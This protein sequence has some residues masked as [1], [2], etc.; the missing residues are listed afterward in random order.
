M[1]HRLADNAIF[2]LGNSTC[3]KIRKKLCHIENRFKVIYI[4]NAVFSLQ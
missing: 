2:Y 3:W 4:T 1:I